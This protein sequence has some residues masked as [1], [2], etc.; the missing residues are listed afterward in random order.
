VRF[1]AV[2]YQVGNLLTV[3]R[4]ACDLCNGGRYTAK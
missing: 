4:G 1:V 3:D 2:Y